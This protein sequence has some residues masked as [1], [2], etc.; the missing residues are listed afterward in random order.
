M[1]FSALIVIIRER[2]SGYICL[3]ERERLKEREQERYFLDQV[4]KR[5]SQQERGSCS[6]NK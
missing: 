1:C 5:L 6:S 2:E 4:I 3:R